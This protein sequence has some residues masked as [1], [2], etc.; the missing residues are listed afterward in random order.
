MSWEQ[1]FVVRFLVRVMSP[2]LRALGL[3]PRGRRLPERDGERRG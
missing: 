1:N 2:L 3:L